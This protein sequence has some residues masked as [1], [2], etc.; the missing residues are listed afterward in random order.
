MRSN[1][2]AQADA[3]L[4]RARRL[5]SDHRTGAKKDGD[6]LDCGQA[7]VRQLLESTACCEYSGL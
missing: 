3:T 2:I 4:A 5:L 7:D 1:A 6:V